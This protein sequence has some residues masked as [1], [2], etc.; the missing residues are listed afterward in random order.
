MTRLT[1]FSLSARPALLAAL[2]LAA[3]GCGSAPDAERTAQATGTADR[4][5]AAPTAG[6]ADQA[7]AED[8]GLPEDFMDSEEEFH[9]PPR[10]RRAAL[11]ETI[12]MTGTNIGV[13]LRVRATRVMDPAGADGRPPRAGRR[14]VAVELQLANTGI[15]VFESPLGDA[16]LAVG[17][18]RRVAP[19]DGAGAS[20]SNGLDAPLRLD[21]GDRTAGCLVFEVP[22]ERQPT[23]LQLALEAEPVADGGTWEL[24]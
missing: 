12:T 22:A 7:D 20:C 8:L 11:G 5:D 18:G 2:A 4:A 19:A 9:Q 23:S 15:T 16:E 14:Y 17:A 10:P 1:A 24:G 21:V 13:R 3:A 6:A